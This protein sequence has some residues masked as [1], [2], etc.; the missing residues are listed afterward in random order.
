[1]M[2]QI[3]VPLW[4]HMG[5]KGRRKDRKTFIRCYTIALK[6]VTIIL[7][8]KNVTPLPQKCGEKQQGSAVKVGPHLSFLKPFQYYETPCPGTQKNCPLTFLCIS[9]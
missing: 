8:N 4:T 6:L 5:Y 7:V 9:D 3:N 1:M 2:E